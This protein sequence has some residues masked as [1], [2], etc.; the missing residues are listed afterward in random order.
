MAS[1]FLKNKAAKRAAK[2]DKAFGVESYGS[3]SWMRQ[4]S[5]SVDFSGLDDETVLREGQSIGTTLTDSLLNG[6]YKD[7]DA[8]A[9][10]SRK[11]SLYSSYLAELKRRGYDTA[12]AEK[13]STELKNAVDEA[14][15][16]YSQFTDEADYNDRYGYYRKYDKSSS[17]DIEK[18]IGELSGKG[19]N[20]TELS[21]LKSHRYEFYSTDEIKKLE[22]ELTQQV[23]KSE[24]S[25]EA[26]A[27]QTGMFLGADSDATTALRTQLAAV[28]NAIRNNAYSQ[29]VAK[30][31]EEHQ[32]TFYKQYGE[33]LNKIS[34]ED[35]GTRVNAGDAVSGEL[36]VS[37][38]GV[39][40]M[41]K[42]LKEQG[43]TD[44]EL[45]GLRAYA[46]SQNNLQRY[47]ESAKYWEGVS[48]KGFWGK[49]GATVA[50]VPANLL[51]GMA[52]V[53][54]ALQGLTNGEDA[55]TGSQI[56]VDYNR[57]PL[58]Y[59]SENMRAAVSKDMS[60]AGQYFYNV[61][62]SIVDFLAARGAMKAT[63]AVGKNIKALGK[64]GK[65]VGN[66]AEMMLAGSAA[67]SSMRAAK[68]RGATDAEAIG[69]GFLSG[70]AEMAGEHAS[71]EHLNTI[72]RAMG[73]AASKRTVA[74]IFKSIGM[75]TT[76]R[77]SS[78]E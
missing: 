35:Q 49:V 14:N 60:E 78:P 45:R 4:Q 11:Y 46:Q 26:L 64:L 69:F 40:E 53:D 56:A 50:S 17:A 61:G 37:R 23:K 51:S 36:A 63:G 32:N 27:R 41:E 16:F 71:I 5:K 43:Y 9:N 67:N 7:A 76:V 28:Q 2:I 21:W 58:A 54:S 38:E 1:D 39:A 65:G 57:S 24:E 66:S 62:M 34:R 75:R 48:D 22:K 77:C 68:E 12:E 47:Y 10:L 72:E 25:D 52:F 33:W 20:N 42:Y 74:N 29:Q 15:N 30:W 13:G 44:E 19:G 70:I 3:S 31:D 59:A 6:S 55:F 8:R 73:N 18:K